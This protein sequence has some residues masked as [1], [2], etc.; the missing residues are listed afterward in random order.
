METMLAFADYLTP[1]LFLAATVDAVLS[2]L[3]FLGFCSRAAAR[4]A[5]ENLRL[6]G[7]ASGKQPAQSLD[8]VL[9]VTPWRGDERPVFVSASPNGAIL[10]F[11]RDERLLVTAGV[12]AL[13]TRLFTLAPRSRLAGLTA[14]RQW[15]AI[16]PELA[17]RLVA[18]EVKDA[19]DV[20]EITDLRAANAMLKTVGEA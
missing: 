12:Y 1:G 4:L 13:H 3:E 10:R 2:R 20:D 14:L 11:E 9:A 6:I 7:A 18:L 17:A 19:I 5:N 8:G 15:F 16:M